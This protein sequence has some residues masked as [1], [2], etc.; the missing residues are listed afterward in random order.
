[1]TLVAAGPA[2]AAPPEAGAWRR[3]AVRSALLP[4]AVLV[5]LLT[6][7]PAGSHRYTVYWHGAS[8]RNTPWTLLTEN[9]RS[10]PVYL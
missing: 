9:L 4:I 10:I 1:M 6:L 2:A 7:A 3:L 5:P 8:V